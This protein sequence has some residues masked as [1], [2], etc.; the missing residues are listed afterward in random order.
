MAK[1]DPIKREKTNYEG[2]L[3]RWLEVRLDPEYRKFFTS[4]AK[5]FLRRANTPSG[6]ECHPLSR[7]LS[8]KVEQNVSTHEVT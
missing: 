3:R 1:K 7:T 4:Y 5:Q 6:M 8:L 2:E